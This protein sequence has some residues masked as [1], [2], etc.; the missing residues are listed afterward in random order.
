LDVNS[1]KNGGGGKNSRNR[2]KINENEL[3]NE[4]LQKV[5]K[6]DKGNDKIK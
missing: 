6:N 5:E 4:D 3:R 1:D 2:Q